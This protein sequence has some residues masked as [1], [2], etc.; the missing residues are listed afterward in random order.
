MYS[1]INNISLKKGSYNNSDKKLLI[2]Y[3]SILLMYKIKGVKMGRGDKRS[4]KGKI[5]AGSSGKTRLSMKNHHK[6]IR[7]NLM[8]K[9]EE[10]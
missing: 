9:K 1:Q 7:E 6:K 2:K 3:K 10:K 8:A 4:R 5:F